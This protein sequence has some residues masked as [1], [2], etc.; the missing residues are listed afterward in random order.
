MKTVKRLHRVRQGLG[1][2]GAAAR[3]EGFPGRSVVRPVKR[4]VV[5]IPQEPFTPA[6]GATP[7]LDDPTSV[8][9]KKTAR[10]IALATEKEQKVQDEKAA[11]RALETAQREQRFELGIKPGSIN[12][13]ITREPIDFQS[14]AILGGVLLLFFMI[15][16]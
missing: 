5:P 15:A 9:F 10:A 12:I 14:V 8:Q 2:P 1:G 11:S 7:G 3:S 13:P 16:R 6:Q 4:Q